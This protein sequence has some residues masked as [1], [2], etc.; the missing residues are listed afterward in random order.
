MEPQATFIR[1]FIGWGLAWIFVITLLAG[2]F[3]WLQPI[4]AADSPAVVASETAGLISN[5]LSSSATPA[6][7]PEPGYNVFY[8]ILFNRAMINP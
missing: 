3:L 4:R 2:L 5:S 7:S 8:P 1:K 6:S